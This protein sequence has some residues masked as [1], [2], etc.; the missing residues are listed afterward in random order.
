M[1]KAIEEMNDHEVDGSKLTV[2][3]FVARTDRL[4]T[5]KPRCSTNLYVKNFPQMEF[6]EE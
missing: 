5:S 6:T 4:G 3:E 1:I 2:C